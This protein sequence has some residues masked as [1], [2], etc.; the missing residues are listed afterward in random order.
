MKGIAHFI[1]GVAIVTFFP[2]V[3][4]R[5][6]GGSIL[7]VLG[8]V[9][10]ILP[11]TL[12]FKFLRY[13][14]RYSLEVDPGPQP[15]ALRIAGRLAR[16]ID[17]AYG[18]GEPQSVLL[19][20]IRL[21][22]DRWRQYTVRFDAHAG[23]VAVK[24]GAVVDT[25]QNPM[26]GTK[27]PEIPGACVHF[28]APLDHAYQDEITIDIFSGPSFTFE[29]QGDCLHVQF[30]DWHRRWSHSLTLAAALGLGTVGLAALI[31]RFTGPVSDTSLW[32]GLVV[33]LGM[34]G[35]ILEDQLGHMGSNL[36]FPFT[37]RRTRGLG[38]LHSG[39]A[40]PNFLTV[41]T[42]VMIILF[43]LDRFS[44]EARLVPGWFFLGSAV[45]IPVV[46]LGAIYHRDR[47]HQ[48][49][50]DLEGLREQEILAEAEGAEMT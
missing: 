46:L 33:G 41:W 16:A 23:A 39:D 29:R 44:A 47:R 34:L 24:I 35:H 49:R 43:N 45:L 22:P 2:E 37:R 5:A 28:V 27:A 8:G 20:T 48:V 13:F 17:Q 19:H 7:P 14:E 12:D 21:G 38:L 40:L 1:T 30:L 18:S 11:D 15:D 36:L 10:G 31:E 4:Q 26:P 6:A 25:G 3:V 9:A 32:A 42:A 50:N